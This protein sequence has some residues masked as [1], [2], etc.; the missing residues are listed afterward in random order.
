[1]ATVSII[2]PVYNAEKTIGRCVDSVLNQEYTDLELILVDD[3]SKDG[4]GP[5]LDRYAAQDSRVRVV[6]KENSG[7]SDTRNRALALATGTYVQ[8]LDSDDWITPDATRLLVRTAEEHRCDLVVSDFYRVVGDRVSHKGDIEEDQVLTREEYA[9]HMME[10]PADF[11]YGVLWNK[12]YRLDII[13]D[14]H[15]EMDPEISWCE[16]FMFNLEYIR[17]GQ[18]FM[19]LQVPIYYYVKT[20]GSLANQN[21]TINNTIRMKLTVFEYYNRFFKTVLDEEEYEKKRLKVYKFL[22]DAAQDGAVPP[23]LLPGAKKLGDERTTVSDEV[24]ESSGLLQNAYRDRML[25]QYYLEPVA[26]KHDISVPE[27]R[28]LLYL[29][30]ADNVGTRRELAALTNLSKTSLTLTMKKLVSRELIS[31]TDVKDPETREKKLLLTFLPETDALIK[32][33]LRAEQDCQNTRLAGFTQE[34]LTQYQQLSQK[35]Q[36]NIQN[37]LQA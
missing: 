16:D 5:I 20:K 37:V 1:M 24:L 8:F 33:L 21:L 12:L 13:R 15:L 26:L 22:I 35:I 14:H 30:Q 32:D 23:A 36:A 11:Y 34:E 4:S 27:A 17:H 7:V 9:T 28:L 25:L 31:L 6:H 3:G 10:N 19:A 2:I 18:R 29:Y